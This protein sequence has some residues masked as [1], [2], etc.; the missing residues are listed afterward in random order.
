MITVS[1][2]TGTI[3]VRIGDGAAVTKEW[4]VVAP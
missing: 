1:G 2:L 4:L 3:E